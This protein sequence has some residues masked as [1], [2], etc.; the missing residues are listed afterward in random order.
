[1]KLIKAKAE[2]NRLWRLCCIEDRI[3]TNS[4]FVVFSST[5]K[6]VAEYNK[7]VKVFFRLKLKVSLHETLKAVR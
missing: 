2:V 5:N 1:M 4:N 7:A 6:Y 3:G